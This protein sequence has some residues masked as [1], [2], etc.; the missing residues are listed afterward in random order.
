[1]RRTFDTSGQNRSNPVISGSGLITPFGEGVALYKASLLNDLTSAPADNSHHG[2]MTAFDT[3]P[4]TPSPLI[5]VL[6]E[7]FESAEL[8][9]NSLSRRVALILATPYGPEN[10]KAIDAAIEYF[11]IFHGATVH[12]V[13]AAC[14]SVG[15]AIGI[16]CTLIRS[17]SIECVVIA[18][19]EYAN[20]VDRI[21]FVSIR[22]L[23]HTVPRP[24]DTARDGILLAEG[25]GALILESPDG[26]RA[27][28]LQPS[29][30]ISGVSFR[31]FPQS[32]MLRLDEDGIVQSMTSAMN[33][34]RITQVDYVHAHATG[35][36]DGDP[37]ECRA[38]AR[39]SGPRDV[40]PLVSSHKGA[41]GHMMRSS[42][43]AGIL[44]GILAIE[45][46]AVP[47]TIGLEAIDT[48]CNMVRHVTRSTVEAPVRNVAV[49]SLGFCGHYSTMIISAPDF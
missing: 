14:A 4:A 35:T 18:G 23:S 48:E 41:I 36:I 30:S 47:P 44:A 29:A 28:K 13:S 17:G 49:N 19:L 43:F 22:G 46:Q 24:F 40:G 26:A 15:S 25:A 6:T 33:Q 38:I 1:M 27:R 20:E 5:R 42:G 8:D 3:A 45:N 10:S 37:V 32:N 7:A 2:Y 11:P 9:P 39:I 12:K 16:G 31:V 21:S 34:A